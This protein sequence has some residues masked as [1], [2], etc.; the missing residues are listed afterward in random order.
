VLKDKDG[1]GWDN[2]LQLQPTFQP[3]GIAVSHHMSRAPGSSSTIENSASSSLQKIYLLSLSHLFEIG[4]MIISFV[5][6]PYHLICQ[7]SAY[8]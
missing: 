5:I 7:N 1:W 3:A 4:P 8:D 2:E 6:D